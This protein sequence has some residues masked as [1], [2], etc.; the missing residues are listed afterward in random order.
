MS[1][2]AAGAEE[3]FQLLV[4]GVDYRASRLGR[5]LVNHGAPLESVTLTPSA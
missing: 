3:G 1:D 4:Q 5:R 2:L